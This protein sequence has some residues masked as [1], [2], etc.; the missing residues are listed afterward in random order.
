MP[1]S[2]VYFLFRYDEVR[3]DRLSVEKRRALMGR[4]K[5]RDTKPEISVRRLMHRLGYRFRLHRADMPGSPDLVFP[6]RRKAIFVH[7]CFWHQHS[8]K[9]GAPPSSNTEFWHK[10]LERN[11]QRDKDV[12]RKLKESGWEVIVIWEC[13]LNDERKLERR[14]NRLFRDRS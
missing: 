14:I 3:M 10:K 11:R 12:S 1:T 8:C 5:N 6:S 9:R 4:V 13:E 2:A 7:G